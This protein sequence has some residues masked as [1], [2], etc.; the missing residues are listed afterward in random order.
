MY[1]R[2]P[3]ILWNTLT[4]QTIISSLKQD[5]ALRIWLILV[6]DKF[7]IFSAVTYN[8]LLSRSM[9]RGAIVTDEISYRN[10]KT[11][12]IKCH[13]NLCRR[14]KCRK[15]CSMSITNG[16]ICS[17]Y[18]INSNISQYVILILYVDICL[19]MFSEK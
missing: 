9:P 5:S 15:F 18:K 19:N 14:N 1:L 6:A 17:L 12:L 10:T 2:L 3:Q 13:L 7:Y 4:S 16:E 8:E 11:D